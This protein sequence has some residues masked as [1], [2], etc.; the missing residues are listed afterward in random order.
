MKGVLYAQSGIADYWVLDVNSRQLYVFREP[1]NNGYQSQVILGE[2]ATISPL[3][4]P[5]L[6][7]AVSQMLAPQR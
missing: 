2:N 4:F 7:I 6:N 5:N 1:N 3:Q